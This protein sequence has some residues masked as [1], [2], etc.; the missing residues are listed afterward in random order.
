MTI[1]GRRK[2]SRYLLARHIEGTLRL[3]DEVAIETL[4]EREIVV[5]SPELCRPDE[6]VT[7]EFP[8]GALRRIC[9]RVAESRPIA[10]EDGSIRHRL[11]LVLNG[12]EVK[13][14]TAAG[15]SR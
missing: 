2:H 10:V 13:V 9:A 8:G 4:T 14:T 5:L 1:L 3:R 15:G 12:S 11:R 6:L 7:L